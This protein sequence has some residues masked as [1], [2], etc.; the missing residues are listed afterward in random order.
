MSAFAL[1]VDYG[2]SNTVAVLRWPDGKTRPLLFDGS[3]L[4]PS[5]VYAAPEGHLSTGRDAVNSARLDPTRYEPN[6]KR[7]VDELDLL[8]GDAPVPLTQVVA[9]TLTRVA[10]EARHVAGVAVDDVVMTYP[11]EWGAARRQVLLD[12]ARAAG[13]PEPRLV[14]EPVAAGTYFSV[15]LAQG[16]PEGGCVVVYDLGAGTFDASVVRRTAAGFETLAY[17]GL[18]DV[19]GVDVDDLVVQ[20]IGA[21]VEPTAPAEW[22]RL[23][24]PQ[25]R[26]DR[27]AARQLRDDARML[28]ERLSRESSAAILVPIVD[29][30]LHVT[31]GEL[32][33]RAL[34]LVAQTVVVTTATIKAARTS[35]DR[36]AGLFLV[37][38]STR[39]P[40]V[41]TELHRA[42][43]IAPTVLDQPELVVAE[44]ALLVDTP[45]PAPAPI[46]PAP[47]PPA[48]MPP[49][50]MP[51]A[52][53]PPAPASSAPAAPMPA[54]PMPPMPTSPVPISAAPVSPVP[55]AVPQPAYPVSAMPAAPVSP[56]AAPLPAPAPVSQPMPL[57]PSRPGGPP[58][59]FATSVGSIVGRA[60][61]RLLLV[62]ALYAA[63]T[64]AGG[65][66]FAATGS[67]VAPWFLAGPI[68][69]YGALWLVLPIVRMATA[70]H[71]A[72]RLLLDGAG[73]TVTL[74]GRQHFLPWAEVRVEVRRRGL[75]RRPVL[76]AVPH[77]RGPRAED[78]FWRQRRS[79]GTLLVADLRAL[80]AKPPVVLAAAAQYLHG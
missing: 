1:S 8:L 3:P 30:D 13:L 17:R 40:L 7:H 14:P 33:G 43:Q 21:V 58:A 53:T 27:R 10:H 65:L 22:A 69:A 72:T 77:A 59:E 63:G 2:T 54:A 39:M 45:A 50:P 46:P 15:V 70:G 47:I 37:G 75:D 28:K 6:P 71:Q 48:P 61:L 51:P 32:E 11:A 18:D 66:T 44:G 55:A 5:A 24:A 34:A 16:V 57:W 29:R 42:T 73:V 67:E 62:P 9:A 23:L 64:L 19:G 36:I 41:A 56:V 74:Q 38:G 26:P 52:L 49:A 80:R 25:T 31:R 35:R 4:L 12:A 20:L 68:W 76:V 79:D 78:P 60:A